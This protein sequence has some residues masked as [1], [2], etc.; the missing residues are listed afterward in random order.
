MNRRDFI[1]HAG[2]IGLLAGL[3]AMGVHIMLKQKRISGEEACDY[4]YLCGACQKINNCGLSR[5]VKFRS[6]NKN[7]KF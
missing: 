2:R 3:T 4:E 7:S 6:G 1:N 5:A